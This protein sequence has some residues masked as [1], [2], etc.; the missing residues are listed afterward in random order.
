MAD[1]PLTPPLVEPDARLVARIAATGDR[2]ALAELG[3][4]HS[5]TLYAVAYSVLLDPDAADGAVTAAFRELLRSARAF[6][7]RLRSVQAWLVEV[8]RR[9]SKSQVAPRSELTPDERPHTWLAYARRRERPDHRSPAGN[10]G[11]CQARD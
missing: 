7:A 4:R 11:L 2:E 8:V 9:I 5:K 6:D 3:V 10:G 1:L